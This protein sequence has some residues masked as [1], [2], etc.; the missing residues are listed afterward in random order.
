M[1]PD[2]TPQ[3][4][5]R[6]PLCRARGLQPTARSLR[7][8][9]GR[10]HFAYVCS[11]CGLL[12]DE[13]SR[14]DEAANAFFQRLMSR[15]VIEPSPDDP[16]GFDLYTLRTLASRF[17]LA[18]LPADAAQAEGLEMPHADLAA[19]ARLLPLAALAPTLVS[20]GVICSERELATVLDRA[21][22]MRSWAR[23]L[24]VLVD[25]PATTPA[26]RDAFV[27]VLS[28]PLEGNFAAQRNALQAHCASPWV[29]QLDADESLSDGLGSRLGRFA[30]LA[31][32]QG[33]VSVGLPRENLVEGRLTDLYPD[34]QYRLNRREI[35]F[36]GVVHERP[37][38]PWQKSFI[39]L[40]GAIQHH[41]TAE[42]VANRSGTYE[43]LNPGGG[44]LFEAAALSRAYSPY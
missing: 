25:R 2:D 16:V 43:A 3:L 7:H 21:G 24:V 17:D 4:S 19:R 12:L 14:N 1:G 34:I 18:A 26:I 28:R 42:H 13:N 41:L 22:D 32:Q 29:L 8:G 9:D 35:L 38:R 15:D 20:V 40:S 39:T 6:C 23:E 44:R 36:E 31:D 33:A 10:R 30:T 27:A 11:H 37:V 5:G